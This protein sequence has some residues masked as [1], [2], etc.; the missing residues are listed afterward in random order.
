MSTASIDDLI[1]NQTVEQKAVTLIGL[2]DAV[3]STAKRFGKARFAQVAARNVKASCELPA[4]SL[5]ASLG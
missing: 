3:L 4:Y 1:G 2:K 5:A